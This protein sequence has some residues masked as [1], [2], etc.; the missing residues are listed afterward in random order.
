MKEKLNK[1]D[2]LAVL[3]AFGGVV[4]INDPFGM[5]KEDDDN[6]KHS[7]LIGTLIAIA[8][9]FGSA[10]AMVCMR[11]MRVGLHHSIAPFY[12]GLG[13]VFFSPIAYGFQHA[14]QDAAA[15][16]P[17]TIYDKQT[18]ILLISIG[19]LTT[20]AQNFVSQSF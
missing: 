8:G 12:F 7:Y 15:Q 14:T 4:L 11:Y 3:L 18:I 2:I 1:Y 13:S 6:Q 16:S 19:L 20:A 5:G 9:S 10:C 17:A